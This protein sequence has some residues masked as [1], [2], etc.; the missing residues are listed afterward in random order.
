VLFVGR[1]AATRRAEELE[2]MADPMAAREL[3]ELIEPAPV[4]LEAYRLQ[5]RY[6][7]IDE[8]V[9]ADAELVSLAISNVRNSGNDYAVDRT[10]H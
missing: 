5:A 9:Y 1:K 8:S 6:L 7:L 3:A 2:G 4:G 10:T